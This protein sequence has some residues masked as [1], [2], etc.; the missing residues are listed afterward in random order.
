MQLLQT[1]L[2]DSKQE[3]EQ[4]Q[5]QLINVQEDNK[6]LEAQL[7]SVQVCCNYGKYNF[8]YH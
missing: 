6:R 8:N 3:V 1:Q 4:L 7:Q 5:L 2:S